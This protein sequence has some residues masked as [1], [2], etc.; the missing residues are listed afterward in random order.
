MIVVVREMHF[1]FQ[2]LPSEVATG[3]SS[4]YCLASHF[5]ELRE[6]SFGSR[7]NSHPIPTTMNFLLQMTFSVLRTQGNGVACLS[8]SE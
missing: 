1:I 4:A 8:A 2:M 3:Q 5:N 6:L 7:A